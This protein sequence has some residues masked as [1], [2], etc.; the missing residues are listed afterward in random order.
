LDGDNFAPGKP[1]PE[2]RPVKATQRD[3]ETGG[4][5][6]DPRHPSGVDH[7]LLERIY[8]EAHLVFSPT[9]DL[10]P[11]ADTVV[12]ALDTNA[13]LLPY[14]LGKGDLSALADVYSKFAQEGRLFLPERVA[15]EFIKNRD[16]KLAEMAQAIDDRISRLSN[17][18]AKVTPLLLEGFP[19]REALATAGE[20]L[21]AATKK[22]LEQ[23]GKLSAHMRSWRGTDPVTTLYAGLFTKERL[24][25]PNES[26]E[27]IL[28]ELE[29]GIRNQVPPGYKDSSKDDQG[30]GDVIIWMSLLYLG[31]TA[32][33]DLIFVTGEQKADWFVRSGNRPVYPR[34]ELV[35]SYRT[36]SGGRSLRLSSLH[37][38]LREMSAPDAFVSEVEVAE[39]SANN[40]IQA[41][42]YESIGDV[43][44][45]SFGNEEFR[46]SPEVGDL[47]LRLHASREELRRIR[48]EITRLTGDDV[49]T[50]LSLPW[51]RAAEGLRRQEGELVRTISEIGQRLRDLQK[52]DAGSS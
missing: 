46:S 47:A 6:S 38:L 44:S 33:K 37:E 42:S 32:K 30:I 49:N 1:E 26:R 13:L 17:W 15:R 2:A 43:A 10:T 29:Y 24:I 31:R 50:S 7:F 36:A 4:K 52:P 34:P 5:K 48:N 28:E 12:V 16:R 21:S 9:A 35:D 39:I 23:L 20:D 8:G 25:A 45:S 40:A 27:K 3:S 22:Y 14:L 11:K 19:E 51:N 41:A 18:D